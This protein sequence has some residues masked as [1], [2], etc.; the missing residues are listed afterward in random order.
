M[1]LLTV[2]LDESVSSKSRRGVQKNTEGTRKNRILREERR[3]LLKCKKQAKASK[4]RGKI[5]KNTQKQL[6]NASVSHIA[7][8]N[9][10]SL[11]SRIPARIPHFSWIIP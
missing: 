8:L 10:R 4:N 2:E 3:K 1:P 6:Q 9:F 7:T 5:M 11:D